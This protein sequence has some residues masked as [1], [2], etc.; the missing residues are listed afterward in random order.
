VTRVSLSSSNSNDSPAPIQA[1]KRAGKDPT[2]KGKASRGPDRNRRVVS[3]SASNSEP[4][5]LPPHTNTNSHLKSQSQA[6]HPSRSQLP[7]KAKRTPPGDTAVTSR[8]KQTPPRAPKTPI[9][10]NDR[11]DLDSGSESESDSELA[12]LGKS[13]A[14]GMSDFFL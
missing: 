4:S 12:F 10:P 5:I 7:P 11:I 6:Q 1:A 8:P 2:G 3:S 9:E 13:I 14:A